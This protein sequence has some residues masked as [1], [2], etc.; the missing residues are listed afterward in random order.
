[1]GLRAYFSN[2]ASR[3]NYDEVMEYLAVTET[4]HAPRF[5]FDEAPEEL[6]ELITMAE[7]PRGQERSQWLNDFA[8]KTWA[9]PVLVLNSTLFEFCLVLQEIS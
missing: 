7:T 9:V 4:Q 5:E 8:K 6:R 3:D 2:W 1:M